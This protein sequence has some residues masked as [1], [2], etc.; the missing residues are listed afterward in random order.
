MI[1]NH[2]I[3]TTIKKLVVWSSRIVKV[4]GDHHPQKVNWVVATHIF[5][6]FSHTWGNDPI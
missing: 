4:Q 3:E 5:F 6:I 1:W 2:P